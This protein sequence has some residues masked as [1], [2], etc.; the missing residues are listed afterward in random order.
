MLEYFNANPMLLIAIAVFVVCLI[1]GF[2]GDKHLKKENKIG[3]LLNND[4]NKNNLDS[5]AYEKDE[6]KVSDTNEMSNVIGNASESQ[7][8]ITA[9]SSTSAE[10][11]N[12]PINEES[13]QYKFETNTVEN[14]VSQESVEVPNTN[15]DVFNNSMDTVVQEPLGNENNSFQSENFPQDSINQDPSEN[16]INNIF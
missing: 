12:D 10:G 8:E 13:L 5:K 3:S 6:N 14:P 7:D 11:Q 9:E 2:L 4:S 1:I 15:Q 16:D